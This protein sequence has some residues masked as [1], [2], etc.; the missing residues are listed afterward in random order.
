MNSAKNTFENKLLAV[1]IF[2]NKPTLFLVTYITK[3]G[4]GSFYFLYR[5]LDSCLKTSNVYL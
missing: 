5:L 2:S 4:N 3:I 1:K